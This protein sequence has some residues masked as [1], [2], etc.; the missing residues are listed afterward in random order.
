MTK[1]LMQVISIFKNRIIDAYGS[2][3]DRLI[4]YGSYARGSAKPD[5]DVDILVVLTDIE[6][7]FTEVDKLNEL[8]YPLLL[9]HDIFI[10]ANPVTREALNQ[11]GMPFFRNILREGIEI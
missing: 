2:R 4:L 11:T 1:P 8:K 6:S 7:A 5:S 3:F 9:E 10:S